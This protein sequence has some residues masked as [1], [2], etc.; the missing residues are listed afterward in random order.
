MS[1]NSLLCFPTLSNLHVLSDYL[2]M[3]VPVSV[4][5]LNCFVMLALIGYPEQIASHMNS[6]LV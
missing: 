3:F 6:I 2:H 5:I 4:W 1:D